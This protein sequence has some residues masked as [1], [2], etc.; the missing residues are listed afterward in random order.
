MEPGIDLPP[1]PGWLAPMTIGAQ[2]LP[3][4]SDPMG[5]HLRIAADWPLLGDP[6][7]NLS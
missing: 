1:Q 5:P 6:E 4:P 2:A 3:G 7:F